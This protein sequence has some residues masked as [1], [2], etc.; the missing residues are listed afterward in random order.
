M[1]LEIDFIRLL[2]VVPG[3]PGEPWQAYRLRLWVCYRWDM[4]VVKYVLRAG[5]WSFTC[6]DAAQIDEWA[7][8]VQ[9]TAGYRTMCDKTPAEVK[10]TLEAIASVPRVL[11]PD[12]GARQ[13][14]WGVYQAKR[15]GF[16][17]RYLHVLL[18][19]S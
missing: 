17:L 11:K 5:T 1:R 6:W 16:T 3:D 15:D 14:W 4:D 7:R 9:T 18:S 13:M 2:R 12:P 8:S 19:T 10:V